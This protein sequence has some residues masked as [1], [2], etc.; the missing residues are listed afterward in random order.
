MTRFW[1]IW[2]QTFQTGAAAHVRAAADALERACGSEV[3]GAV[4]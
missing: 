1:A 2:F 3:A 4:E